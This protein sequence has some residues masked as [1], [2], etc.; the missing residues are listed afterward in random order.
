M[1][2]VLFGVRSG[3]DFVTRTFNIASEVPAAVGF[4]LFAI[5]RAVQYGNP[6]ASVVILE[7][8]FDEQAVIDAHES[9]NYTTSDLNDLTL[10]CGESGCDSGMEMNLD[11]VDPA[12]PFGGDL[13]RSQP[14]IVGES[15][16]ASS[17]DAEA[18]QAAADTIAEASDSLADNPDYRAAA[19]AIT[20][21]GTLIQSYF[22]NP[23]DIGTMEQIFA[24]PRL[25]PEQVGHIREMLGEDFV[26]VPP[27]SL[28]ALA[29]TATEDQQQAIVALVYRDETAA[30]EAAA[31][32]PDRLEQYVSLV[33]MES[34]D[35]LLEERG[36]IDVEV[37]IYPT[38]TDRYVLLLTLSAPLAGEQTDD[39][40]PPVGASMVYALLVQAYI[41]R[42]LGW[43]ATQP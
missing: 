27:Y 35:I 26:P 29:D 7:G 14:V 13:G 39:S 23:A 10:L 8:D 37:T 1:M 2:G 20:Q 31:L 4:D 12:N 25:S 5:E 16:I 17:P 36:V 38:S 21:G 42:D 24:N 30:E 6:P 40:Q 43:L 11:T 33:A 32:F 3:P 34:F 19:E 18:L 28:I 41:T 9:R 15:L 22:V